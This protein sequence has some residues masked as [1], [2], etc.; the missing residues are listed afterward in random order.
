MTFSGMRVEGRLA[1]ALVLACVVGVIACDFRPLRVPAPKTEPSAT[2]PTSGAVPFATV[3]VCTLADVTSIF[4]FSTSREGCTRGG[5]CHDSSGT[6][7]GLSLVADGWDQSLVGRM[8][9]AT[10][11]AS[12]SASMCA[13]MGYVYLVP[14]S[15]P[16]AGLLI[17][18]LD[19]AGQAPCGA[20]MPGSGPRLT[21]AEFDC[22]R[23]WATTLTTGGPTMRPPSMERP[24]IASGPCAHSTWTFSASKTC[25]MTVEPSSQTDPANAIDGDRTT[26]YTTCG[27][28]S[29]GEFVTVTFAAPVSI[30]GIRLFTYSVTDFPVSYDVTYSTDGVAFAEFSPPV[31][32]AGTPDLTISFPR[33]TMKAFKVTQTGAEPPGNPS[34]WSIHELT[35][36]DCQT[37]V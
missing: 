6:A 1:A 2:M 12:S 31:T 9:S 22:V 37:G 35:V 11:S 20:N 34:W 7:A 26:R 36:S 17:D 3:G 24:P 21:T 18:K 8:P 32:G 28:Q 15:A 23:S 30:D 29:G 16:A 5:T 4:T 19:P 13:G 33:T 25:G 27:V 14:G 10:A